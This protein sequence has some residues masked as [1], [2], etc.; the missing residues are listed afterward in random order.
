M[1]FEEFV[2]SVSASTPPSVGPALQALWF[3]RKGDWHRAHALAQA[4]E[5]ATGSWVHAYL[6]RKEGEE[7]NAGYWYRRAGKP[8]ADGPLESEWDSIVYTLLKG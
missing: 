4:D 7:G 2:T 1:S 8:H 5:S 3:D 6:H